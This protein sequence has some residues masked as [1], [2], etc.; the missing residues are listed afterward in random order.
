MSTARLRHWLT[1]AN[2][3][4][5]VAAEDGYLLGYG[6]AIYRRDSRSGRVYSLAVD[7]GARGRGV[8]SVLM[9]ALER[10]A[11]RRGCREMRLEVASRNA[12][13]VS[14]YERLGYTLFGRRPAYYEDG[15]TALR[16][17]KPL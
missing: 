10:D 12:A 13:A 9:A 11:R 17:R 2:G 1:A 8:A 5:Q 4:L 3:S 16:L 15:D 7:P 6:L 14:L